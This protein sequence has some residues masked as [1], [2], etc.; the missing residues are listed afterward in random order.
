MRLRLL[1]P[2]AAVAV[3]MLAYTP[4]A[5]ACGGCFPPQGEQASIVTDHR[6][7]M[8]VSAQQSTLYDQI[9]Y[10][11]SPS[12]FAWILPI[13]QGGAAVVGISADSLFNGLDTLTSLVIQEPPRNCPRPPAECTRDL[14]SAGSGSSSGGLSGGS[15]DGGVSV[16]KEEVVGPYQTV[17]L[18]PTTENDTAAVLDW[19]AANK[20]VVPDDIKPI[21]AQ[22]T[23]EHFNFLA[24]RL[25]PGEG[26]QSMRPVR[27]TTPGSN[28]AL[29][30]RMVAAGT[31]ANVGIT[32]WVVSNGRFQTTNFESFVIRDEEITWDWTTGTSNYR[33]LRAERTT[34]G[35]GKVWEVESSIATFR[36]QIASAARS[37]AIGG[38]AFGA[39]GDYLEVKDEQTGAIEKTAAQVEDEDY[40][41]L[42]AG[43]TGGTLHVTRLRAD[44][45]R[46]ALANDLTV[47]AS[48][49]QTEVPR[50][51]QPKL[52]NGQPLCPVFRGCDATGEQLPRDEAI[53]KSSGNETDGTFT[54]RAATSRVN[55]S[56]SVALGFL[57]VVMGRAVRRR[58]RS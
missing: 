5:E 51:R 24:L 55:A 2:C 34:A 38:G 58:R 15:L 40:D 11:G 12:E 50:T 1:A 36:A 32:L 9:R 53:A 56:V 4:P 26:V 33:D 42:E 14:D 54:C 22:Y 27:V 41:V 49:D 39:G 48:S 20:Y 8:T 10:Q 25:R 43:L 29:P 23:K 30:L 16:I 47:G 21:I 28:V 44:L 46:A 3:S 7:V 6:M 18:Q 35:E 17:Q 52:E 19:L 13:T 45:T 31:G 37:A 57:A